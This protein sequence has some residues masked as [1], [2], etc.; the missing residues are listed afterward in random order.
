MPK[1]FPTP[2]EEG[3]A[4]G[5]TPPNSQSSLMTYME[6]NF[7]SVAERVKKV[8]RHP[9]QDERDGKMTKKEPQRSGRYP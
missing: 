1:G 7:P 4:A 3:I 2:E 5:I 9:V 6:R 8:V